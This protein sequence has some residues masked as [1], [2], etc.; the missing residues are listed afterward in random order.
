MV[1]HQLSQRIASPLHRPQRSVEG[2]SHRPASASYSTLDVT[3]R[4]EIGDRKEEQGGAP[5]T[6]QPRHLG[7]FLDEAVDS[8]I[9]S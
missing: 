3:P 5:P 8:V 7:S 6:H 2:N 4:F 9:F 1:A